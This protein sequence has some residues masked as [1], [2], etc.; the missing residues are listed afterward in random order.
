MYE[1][2]PQR[3]WLSAESELYAGIANFFIRNFNVT[4]TRSLNISRE[5]TA[6]ESLIYN[7]R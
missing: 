5:I 6:P 3:G 2:G 7:K 4:V 1:G